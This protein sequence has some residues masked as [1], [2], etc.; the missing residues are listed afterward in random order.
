MACLSLS[1]LDSPVDLLLIRMPTKL[2]T[3]H[4]GT[5]HHCPG[6]SERVRL[7]WRGTIYAGLQES[8][9]YKNHRAKVVT[10]VFFTQLTDSFES[11]FLFS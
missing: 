6:S 3:K 1:S 7:E 2:E 9:H 4:F 5:A 8:P 10:F 11:K